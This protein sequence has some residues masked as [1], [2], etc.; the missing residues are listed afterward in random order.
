MPFMFLR[1]KKKMITFKCKNYGDRFGIT[2]SYLNFRYSREDGIVEHT[3]TTKVTEYVD[4]KKIDERSY[5][6]LNNI[7]HNKQKLDII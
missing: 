3:L 5:Y 2:Y 4:G 1:L 7:L 6:E